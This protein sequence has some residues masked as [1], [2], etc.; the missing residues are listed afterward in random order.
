M[1]R[2][3][4]AKKMKKALVTGGSRGIGRAVVET[5]SRKGYEVYSPTRQELDLLSLDSIESYCASHNDVIFDIL[6]NDAGLNDINLVENITEDELQKMISVNLLAPIRLI[7]HVVVNMKKQNY[8]RIVNIG[9]IWGLAGKPGRTVYA[10]TKH[11]IHGITQTLAVE[12][13]PYNIL[14]NTVCPGFTLTELTFKNNTQAQIQ[15]IS[16]FIPMGRMAQPEE[17]AAVICYLASEVNT[18]ITGQQL[19]VDGGYTAK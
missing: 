7:R 3:K 14:I 2:L 19:A 6:I 4:R 15:E 8:G 11:G 9:S 5:L 1:E 17:Q 16:G 13:A 10:A 12:L 18:Y